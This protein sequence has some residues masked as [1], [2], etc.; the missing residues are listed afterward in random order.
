M[1]CGHKVLTTRESAKKK[2]TG[3]EHAKISPQTMGNSLFS[4]AFI[5]INFFKI[6]LHFECT[7]FDVCMGFNFTI[8]NPQQCFPGES[9]FYQRKE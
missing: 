8:G 4:V 6:F 3:L 9:Y 7:C 5:Q 2:G 1:H